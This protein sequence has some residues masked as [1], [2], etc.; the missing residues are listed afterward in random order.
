MD[1]TDAYCDATT[2]Y[3]VIGGVVVYADNNHVS[4]TY[5]RTLA[6][7]LGPRIVAALDG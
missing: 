5:A 2:C 3:T 7:Y 1:L 4:N 6:P